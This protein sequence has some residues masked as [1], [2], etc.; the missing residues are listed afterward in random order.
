MN[1]LIFNQG[2][3]NLKGA[4]FENFDGNQKTPTFQFS[5]LLEFEEKIERFEK[6][7]F[8][9]HRVT[10]GGNYF[11]K[12]TFINEEVKEKILSLSS[13]SPLHNPKQLQKVQMAEKKFPKARHIAFFDTSFHQS[14]KEEAYT[15]PIPLKYREMGIRKFG[16]H[17][18]NFEYVLNE[19]KKHLSKTDTKIC[20]CHLGGGSSLAAIKNGISIDTTM[21]F[22]PLEGLMM[23][24]RSGSIDPGILFF[25][26]NT[27]PKGEIFKDLNE[28][29]GLLGL[30]EI[31]PKMEVILKEI[32]TGNRKAQLSLEVYIHKLVSYLGA[33]IAKLEGVD[34]IIFSGG[35]GENSP[36]VRSLALRSFEFLNLQISSEL[37]EIIQKEDRI[38]SS[39]DSKI[40]VAVIHANEAFYMASYIYNN[41]LTK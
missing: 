25:L 7:D 18:I 16:F 9:A 24:T 11:Q 5:S 33:M 4:F 41:F 26:E 14:L 20:I 1:I 6:I 32:E 23:S 30:S 35:I 36:K 22:T 28:K 37:N 13:F 40:K 15:Y 17:G 19:S 8:I 38:I 21:G 27:F 12:P 2:S 10:H 29:S 34:A 31:S 39:A 3:D